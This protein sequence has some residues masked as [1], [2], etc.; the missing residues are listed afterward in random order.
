[1]QEA[2]TAFEALPQTSVD[3]VRI[4][5]P[6][7]WALLRSSVTEP[8]LTFR[9]EGKTQDDLDQIVREFCDRVPDLGDELYR[10]YEKQ[11]GS[12]EA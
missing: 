10:L 7:G 12:K 8:K 6:N 11:S 1:M 9:F 3:G 2:K 4:E 5:F